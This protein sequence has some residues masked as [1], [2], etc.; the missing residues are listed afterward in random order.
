MPRHIRSAWLKTLATVA[1]VLLFSGLVGWFT[2]HLWLCIALG[3][4]ATLAW[5]YWRLRSVLRRLTARQRWDTAE[6][7]TGVWNELDRLLYRNQVEMRVRKRRLLDMLRSYRAA[8]AALP[9][10]VVVLDRNSQRVQ[11]FNEAAT[12]LLGLHHPGDL[13]EALVERLQ[14]MPLA[15]WLAGGRNAEPILDVPSPV[16]PAIRL[17]LRLIP[18]RRTTGC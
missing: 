1:A 7:G 16:D 14:P 6:E 9:D 17:N 3:A 8:A 15:H 2:G 4:L 10:A 13:G 18:I 12:A 5:H 11:W